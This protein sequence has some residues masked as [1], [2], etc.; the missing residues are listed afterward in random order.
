LDWQVTQSHTLQFNPATM[1]G[2]GLDARSYAVKDAL[3]LP[4]LLHVGQL[5][6]VLACNPA[7]EREA[8]PVAMTPTVT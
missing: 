7:L 6:A 1:Q 8:D 4:P 3:I 5:T 2:V